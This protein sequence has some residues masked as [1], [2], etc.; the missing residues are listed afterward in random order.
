MSALF[1]HQR[2]Y[3]EKYAQR[4]G[5]ALFWEQ[6]TGKTRAALENARILREAG[7][8]GGVLL[9]APN[10]VHRQWVEQEGPEHTP[11]LGQ[12]WFL[13][14]TSK[15]GGKKYRAELRKAVMGEFPFLA[16]SYDAF[17]TKEGRKWAQLMLERRALWILDE[18]TSIKSPGAKRTR[19]IVAAA[20]KAAYRRILTG[21][22]VTN[23][24]FDVYAQVKFLDPTFWSSQGFESYTAFKN[25]FGLWGRGFNSQQGREFPQLRGFRHID[26]LR[27]LLAQVGHRVLKDDV[28]DLPPKLY[29]R[30]FFEMSTDQARAYRELRDETVAV[31]DGKVVEADL[32]MVRLLRLQQVTCGYL[33]VEGGW[34]TF[35]GKN[36]RLQCFLQLAEEVGHQAIVWCRFQRDVDLVYRALETEGYT[37]VKYDGTVPDPLRARAKTAFLQGDAQWFVSNPA[38]AGFGHTFVNARTVVYYSNSFDLEERIQS[39]DRA[40]RAGQTHK[41]EYIDIVAPGTVDEHILRSLRGKFNIAAGVTGDVLRSW[42]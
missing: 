11:D 32:A 40:H 6:G 38:A 27:E 13:Y 17:M 34:H 12:P 29:A 5:H 7:A 33:P 18:S 1:D 30:R 23:R 4:G 37:A 19:A 3:L 28:L 8:V 20:P 42:L 35:L 26:E 9:V 36:A 25:Y 24:P 15:A 22:P 2:T 31:L 14:E 10:G 16:M 21:T 39:E 41:V